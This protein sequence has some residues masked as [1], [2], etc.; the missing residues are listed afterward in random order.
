VGANDVDQPRA[1]TIGEIVEVEQ[2][3]LDI[4]VRRPAAAGDADVRE[5]IGAQAQVGAG[6]AQHRRE[7]IAQ[8]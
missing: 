2:G 3:Q 7:A 4:N 8:L 5:L 1:A 6:E